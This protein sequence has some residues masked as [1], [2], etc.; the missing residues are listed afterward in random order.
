L[1]ERRAEPAALM[2]LRGVLP[3]VAAGIGL[4]AGLTSPVGAPLPTAGRDACAAA[5][6]R[7]SPLEAAACAAVLA[8]SVEDA[9]REALRTGRPWQASRLL[10]PL[11]A[12]S[13][14]ASAR[15]ATVLLAAEAA[16]AWGGHAE[17]VRLL[18]GRPWLGREQHGAG[19]E[20]LAAAYLGQR[21]DTL[22]LAAAHAAVR[23]ARGGEAR[24]RRLVYLARA[25]DRLDLRDSASVAYLQAAE[26]LPTIA[27]WLR[28]RSAIVTGDSAERAARFATITDPLVRGRIAW[29]EA[30][31]LERA[32]DSARAATAW[33][34][35]GA[36]LTALG[37]RLQVPAARDSAREALFAF[38]ARGPAAADGRAAATLLRR[39][40][41]LSAAEQL[42][43]AQALD[44]GGDAAGAVTAYTAAFA[45]GVGTAN[46]RLAFA[47]ALFRLGRHAD[48]AKAYARMT[49]DHQLGG[50]AAYREARALVRLNEVKRALPLLRRI[51]D[52]W[53]RDT[54]ASAQALY[55]LGDLATDDGSGERS[56]AYWRQL[57]RRYPTS[58]LAPTAWFRAGM[59]EFQL[60]DYGRAAGFLDSL[61]ARHPRS[62]EANAARY[63]AGRARAVLGD[64]AAAAA[65]WRAI[66]AADPFSYY[67][68]LASRRLDTLMALPRPA[69]D[70]FDAAPDI[71]AALARA[72]LLAALGLDPEARHE[73]AAAARLAD[74][75]SRERLLAAAHAFRLAGEATQASR[76][77]ARLLG[78]TAADARVWRLAYP[79]QH[80]DAIAST[81]AAHGLDPVF[82]TALI[83]QESA[84]DAG[85]VSS[86]DARGLMQ[87]LPSV[88]QRT[89]RGLRYP[90]WD[91]ALLFQPDVNLELGTAHLRELVTK[92]GDPVRVL[93]AY[94]AGGSRV[95]RWRTSPGAEDPELFVERIPYA[96]TRDYVR[97][98]VRNMELYRGLYDWGAA[99]AAGAQ[100]E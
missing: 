31:A 24:A 76:L 77:A 8:D 90:L 91:E 95:D 13:A 35:A 83:R 30:Q 80:A 71:T 17:V 49:A 97:I 54:S 67:A 74:G 33:V 85:A 20:F 61:A 89:A 84:F 23:A 4:L 82:G 64:T 25:Y 32:G 39:T 21:R 12:D 11:V 1:G 55:L 36:P 79:R 88:G 41:S 62:A 29:S 22:A 57:V 78:D 14:A 47:D 40:G 44:R 28:L 3:G 45:G 9:A 66:R 56:A 98:I 42:R 94:N 50:I 19:H 10:A 68:V 75:G 92:Y 65:R 27:D 73:R 63:W 46:D 6:E 15:P 51:P 18:G 99:P 53:P 26:G 100:G 2:Q 5:P 59:A 81:A 43:V 87:L 52:R 72:Q 60:G 86:A 70:R 7:R 16:E 58:R 48:A 69:N 96:E 93:A 37:L 34:R 38:L